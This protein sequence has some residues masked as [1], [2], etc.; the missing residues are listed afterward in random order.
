MASN[1]LPTRLK[2]TNNNV[3]E[4]SVPIFCLLGFNRIVFLN[5]V[6]IVMSNSPAQ[7]HVYAPGVIVKAS[8]KGASYLFKLFGHTIEYDGTT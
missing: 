1:K 4:K 5:R 8:N 3:G 6:V 2:N 7:S